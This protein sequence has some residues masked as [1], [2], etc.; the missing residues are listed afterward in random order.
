MN[1]SYEITIEAAINEDYGRS[2][3]ALYEREKK[4]FLASPSTQLG[5]FLLATIPYGIVKEVLD[6]A[7]V[8]MNITKDQ[9]CFTRCL[10]CEMGCETK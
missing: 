10:E 4:R 8:E 9:M 3:F 5:N 2:V 7:Y 6:V 1:N